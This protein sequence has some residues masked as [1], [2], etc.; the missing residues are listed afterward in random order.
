MVQIR[1]VPVVLALACTSLLAVGCGPTLSTSVRTE[2]A[3]APGNTGVLSQDGL[4]IEVPNLKQMPE[5]FRVEV[6]VCDSNGNPVVNSGSGLASTT[7]ITALP[8]GGD[9]F[10]VKLTNQTDHVVRLQGSVIRLFDPGENQIE[11]QS[12]EEVVA[13]ASRPSN[14]AKQS[15]CPAAA[16]KITDALTTVRFIG[17]NTE[18]LPGTTTTGYLMFLPPNVELPGTWKLSLYEI[19]VKV[20][21]VGA[22]VAKTRFDFGYVRKKFQDTYSTETLGDRKLIDIKE[23][24]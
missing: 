6:P 16:A 7:T 10:Q 17:A 12:K 2:T 15:A 8:I 19:T 1:R 5:V 22:A 9:L 20:D 13:T 23:V 21:A 24:P 14:L 3:F 18:L 4:T 11:P